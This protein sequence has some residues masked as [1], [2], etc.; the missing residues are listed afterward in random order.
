MSKSCVSVILKLQNDNER[1]R[2]A[3]ADKPSPWNYSLAR[4]G[5]FSNPFTLSPRSPVLRFFSSIQLQQTPLHVA[6]SCGNRDAVAVLLEL[7]ADPKAEDRKGRNPGQSWLKQVSKRARADIAR[8]LEAAV[9]RR[10]RAAAA[11]EA[12]ERYGDDDFDGLDDDDTDDARSFSS[13]SDSPGSVSLSRSGSSSRRSGLEKQ[14]SVSSSVCSDATPVHRPSM[15]NLLPSG[16]GLS[17]RGSGGGRHLGEMSFG[18]D[19]RGSGI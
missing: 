15:L 8:A 6:A 4:N 10:K 2:H 9:D 18:A 14:S 1:R 7:N 13:C 12:A 3:A 5:R 19:V 16:W 11:A 17:R